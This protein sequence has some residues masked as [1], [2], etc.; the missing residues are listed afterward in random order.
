MAVPARLNTSAEVITDVTGV[1][2]QEDVPA[3]ASSTINTAVAQGD[4]TIILAGGGGTNFTNGDKLRVGDRPFLEGAVLET[5]ATDTLTLENDLSDAYAVGEAVVE[6]VDTPIGDLT[7]AG[8]TIEKGG[9]DQA[10]Q[11][12][13][14]QGA[15]TFIPSNDQ[16][17]TFNFELLNMSI[18]NWAAAMGED[19]S[20]RASGLGTAADPYI[21]DVREEFYAEQLEKVWYFTGARVDGELIR[22]EAFSGKIFSP[23][24]SI[25]FTQGEAASLP[26][27]LRVIHG[28][29]IRQ[30]S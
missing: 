17:I 26:F 19:S 10:V 29:R 2:I 28:Y 23:S 16:D 5:K 7:E 27:T 25:T 14:H 24:G 6:V 1:G 8:I 3:G 22:V 30:W 20:L 15:Y 18:E 4:R 13:T 21:L 9:G 12:G 11:S